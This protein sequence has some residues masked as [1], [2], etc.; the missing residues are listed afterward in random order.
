ML[1]LSFDDKMCRKFNLMG[2]RGRVGMVGSNHLPLT[3]ARSNP[4][5]DFVLFHLRKLSS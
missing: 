2:D 1:S 3:L 4:A 5:S